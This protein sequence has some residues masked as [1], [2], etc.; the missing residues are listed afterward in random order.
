MENSCQS[1]LRVV[2]SDVDGTLVHYSE[3]PQNELDA[4]P[5]NPI[6][7]LPPSKTGMRGIISSRTLQLCRKVRQSPAGSNKL[8]CFVL[9]SGMR[10]ST[11]L[12]R[13]PFL[14][15]ADA[16]CCEAGG[17]IFYPIELNSEMGSKNKSIVAIIHPKS[18]LGASED[19]LKPF[20]LI[21]DMEW[22]SQMA[23][24]DAAGSDGYNDVPMVQRKGSLWDYARALVSH[25]YTIDSTGYSSC[26]RVNRKQQDPS[27]IGIRQ[28]D[29]LT[30]GT[31]MPSLSADAYGLDSS[32]NLGCV[33][34]YPRHSGKKNCCEYLVKRFCDDLSGDAASKLSE[35]AV[36]LCDDD[37][38]LEMAM[39][40][41]HAFVPSISSSSMTETIRANPHQFTLTENTETMT[42]MTAATE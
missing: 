12:Q 31:L 24:L 30:S 10:T 14:P 13:L 8:V 21:E 3:K 33:D 11:L 20:G 37:N 27:Q 36:C 26:F 1:T 39:A 35:F 2:F 29:A 40:C 34:F 32:V 4:D 15:K 16:Y 5:V 6:L 17:R 22:K 18:F 23:Q 7:Y 28:W 25:G 42:V 38:D 9:I 19:D 41:Q